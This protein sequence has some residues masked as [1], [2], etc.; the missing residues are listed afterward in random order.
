MPVYTKETF[1][2]LLELDNVDEL[3]KAINYFS[4]FELDIDWLG[5]QL[6]KLTNYPNEN[7]RNQNANSVW[8]FLTHQ[9]DG[10]TLHSFIEILKMIMIVM[11]KDMLR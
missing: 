2:R 11:Y 9:L 7:I 6:L 8:N 4:Q 10:E 3:V 5:N 1:A